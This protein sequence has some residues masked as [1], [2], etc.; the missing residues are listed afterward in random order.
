MQT[1]ELNSSLL[2]SESV[3]ADTF[4]GIRDGSFDLEKF[5]QNFTNIN[6]SVILST[7]GIP[8]AQAELNKFASNVSLLDLNNEDLQF[9]EKII[10]DEQARIDAA[11]ANVETQKE[12]LTVLK[13]Q[14]KSLK[15]QIQF[16]EFIKNI[17][18]KAENP[19]ETSLNIAKAGDKNEITSTVKFLQT[20]LTSAAI[21]AKTEFETLRDT[22]KGIA[23]ELST[24]EIST[25]LSTSAGNAKTLAVSLQDAGVQVTALNDNTLQFTDQFTRTTTTVDLLK[26]SVI[27]LGGQAVKTVEAL[28]GIARQTVS[29]AMILLKTEQATAGERDK[30]QKL[31]T[32]EL[33]LKQLIVAESVKQL[34]AETALTK[35]RETADKSSQQLELLKLQQELVSAT[36]THLTIGLRH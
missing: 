4:K 9:L 8:K 5:N 20:A 21:N 34:V 16:N 6:N 17:T 22:L 30:T 26:D 36:A 12:L 19:F 1:N 3:L 23:P 32:S 27:T 11:Q 25:A 2:R 31:A 15:Q 7:R 33:A 29:E 18:P 35:L 14:E 28:Q 13:D 10:A 24:D